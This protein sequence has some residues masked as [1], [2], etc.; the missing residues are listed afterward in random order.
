[1]IYEM[2]FRRNFSAKFFGTAFNLY[3]FDDA[4]IMAW[5]AKF[6][7]TGKIFDLMKNILVRKRDFSS[8]S[9]VLDGEPDVVLSIAENICSLKRFKVG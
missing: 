3:K 5:G 7:L 1:M 2:M 4:L 9:F 6:Q 8:F